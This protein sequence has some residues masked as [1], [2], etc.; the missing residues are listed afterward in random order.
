MAEHP[1]SN[2][3]KIGNYVIPIFAVLLTV[4]FSTS[5]VMWGDPRGQYIIVVFSIY[6][7]LSVFVSYWHRIT[8]LRHQTTQK[9][10]GAKHGRRTDLSTPYVAFFL[11]LHFVLIGILGVL[12]YMFRGTATMASEI[13]QQYK[14]TSIWIVIATSTAI[15]AAVSA[16]LSYRLSRRI[17]DEIKSD[18][19]I[20][21][22]PLHHIGL[23]NQ[24][25]DKCVLRCTL[26]NKSKRKAYV[27]SVE[28]FDSKK[29]KIKITWSNKHNEYGEILDPT[30]L[31]GVEDSVN[32]VMRRN[33]GEAFEKTNVRIKH[34]LSSDKIELTYDPNAEW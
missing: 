25:H 31:L 29:S 26:F 13:V 14:D 4:S 10:K 17:Y 33:D 2:I 12:I 28:A 27:S 7:M 21:P 6:T 15:I 23:R 22:G 5:K 3:T 19:V 1:L 8:W 11:F 32:L 16:Y 30:D 9:V 34:S 24:D 20:I 18:E